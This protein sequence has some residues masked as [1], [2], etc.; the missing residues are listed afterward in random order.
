MS[1]AIPLAL[2]LTALL[3]AACAKPI[4]AMTAAELLGLGEKYLL[5][6]DYEQAIVCFDRLIEIEPRNPRGYTGLAEVYAARGEVDRAVE[7]MRKG[8]DELSGDTAFLEDLTKLYNEIIDETPANAD[9]YLGLA[10]V[11][12][13]LGDENKSA[14]ILR[15]GLNKLD[16]KRIAER[17]Y[18]LIVPEY[19]IEQTYY[20]ELRADDGVLIWRDESSQ[21]VFAG[22]GARIRKMNAVFASEIPAGSTN[23]DSDWLLESYYSREG[24]T[25]E[26][27]NDGRVGGSA[28]TW[29]ESWRKNQYISFVGSSEWDG[30]GPHGGFEYLGHTFDCETGESLSISDVLS[31]GADNLADTLY[32]EYLSYHAALGDGYDI[33]AQGYDGQ[34]YSG[35]YNKYFVESVKEQCGENAVFWL[36]EDGVHIYFEQYTFYYAAGSSELVI[37]YFRFDL[38]RAPFASSPNS[39]QET[40]RE[41][42]SFHKS[43][44]ENFKFSWSNDGTDSGKIAVADW[45]GDDTPE[46]LYL[47]NHGLTVWTYD[48]K[49]H[50]ARRIESPS[51]DYGTMCL[52]A[53]TTSDDEFWIYHTSGDGTIWWD[54]WGVN[55]DGSFGAYSKYYEQYKYDTPDDSPWYDYYAYWF[56]GE[57]DWT[58]V[59]GQSI[60]G[61]ELTREAFEDAIRRALSK[62]ENVWFD[63]FNGEPPSLWQKHGF[64]RALMPKALAVSYDEAIA[65]L[66]E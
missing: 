61:T 20:D 64:E 34:L 65:Y 40:Y 49:S 51:A 16:D 19:D 59:G 39:W 37:P 48:V 46:L 23:G 31:V 5:E 6:M 4:S 33:F 54:I 7:I 42:L 18:D 38:V 45:F 22:D 58:A 52:L 44:I 56:G 8:F 29:E 53:F 57:D 30:L 11:Y 43:E 21:P 28:V 9:A 12:A 50:A 10:D 3:F 32:Q 26:E 2:A 66:A 1:R 14:E 55:A 13:A 25:Y 17:Y 63:N 41:L 15:R 62:A 36:A 47:S 24:Y 27:A 60:S 35:S